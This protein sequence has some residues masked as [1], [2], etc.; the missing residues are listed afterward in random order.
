VTTQPRESQNIISPIKSLPV[1]I[2]YCEA[3]KLFQVL[4]EQLGHMPEAE[5]MKVEAAWIY[6][7]VFSVMARDPRDSFFDLSK[8]EIKQD[9]EAEIGD[10][11]MLMHD[12]KLEVSAW[13]SHS[14]RFKLR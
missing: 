14:F 4:E 6:A 7:G 5:D 10:V 13:Q 3:S 8:P 12:E 2:A 11:L 9:V 1:R